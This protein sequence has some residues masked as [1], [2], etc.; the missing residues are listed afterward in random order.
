MYFPTGEKKG[1]KSKVNNHYA[2]F[3]ENGERETSIALN[4]HFSTEEELQPYLDKGFVPISDDDQEKYAT[5]Q[6]IRGTDGKPAEKPPYVP[7]VE[8]KLAAIRVQRDRLLSDS[9]K[10]MLPDYP[11]TDEQRAAWETYRQTLRDFPETCDVD[12][13]IWPE[14]P[15]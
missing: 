14:Q 13:Q 11:I 6:Y 2:K 7:T 9:D 8:E 3:K 12:N 4:V 1:D 15:Q 5:G 10:Y